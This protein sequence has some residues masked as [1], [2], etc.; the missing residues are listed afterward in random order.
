MRNHQNTNQMRVK[1]ALTYKVFSQ[2]T[3]GINAPHN[4]YV[5]TRPIDDPNILLA[6]NDDRSVGG[7]HRAAKA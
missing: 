7:I 3:S 5:S 4:G 2:P 1:Q 6:I